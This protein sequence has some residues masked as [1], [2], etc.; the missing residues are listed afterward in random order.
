[1]VVSKKIKIIARLY[2]SSE[3]A[4]IMPYTFGDRV[5]GHPD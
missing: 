1:M 3:I 5:K 4:Q 2:L